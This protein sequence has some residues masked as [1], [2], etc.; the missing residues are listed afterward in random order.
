V[1][2]SG[3]AWTAVGPAKGAV[4]LIIVNVS[5]PSYSVLHVPSG[6][7]TP[8][9][10]CQVAALRTRVIVVSKAG[11]RSMEKSCCLNFQQEQEH[12]E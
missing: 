5:T 7:L 6:E 3:L 9:G 10:K 4:E 12:C 1:C 8:R 2:Q 11:R